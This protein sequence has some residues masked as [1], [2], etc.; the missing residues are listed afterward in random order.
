[1]CVTQLCPMGHEE[2]LLRNSGEVVDLD[3]KSV[4]A[5]AV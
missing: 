3:V 4:S 5:T 2:R 1:M